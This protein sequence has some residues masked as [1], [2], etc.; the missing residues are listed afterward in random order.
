LYLSE[1]RPN[2]QG[3]T[4]WTL[5]GLN[6]DNAGNMA[7]MMFDIGIMADEKGL[8]IGGEKTFI[9]WKDLEAAKVEAFRDRR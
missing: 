3:C 9:S 5:R 6:P 1:G 2:G 7:T 4:G 8:H